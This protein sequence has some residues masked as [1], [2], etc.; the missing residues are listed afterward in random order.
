MTLSSSNCI[1]SGQGGSLNLPVQLVPFFMYQVK[2]DK[3]PCDKRIPTSRLHLSP[4][5]LRRPSR[6]NFFNIALSTT[7]TAQSSTWRE[8][9]KRKKRFLDNLKKVL[10][11]SDVLITI[12]SCSFMRVDRCSVLGHNDISDMKSD[13]VTVTIRCGCQGSAKPHK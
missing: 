5:Y 3:F 10:M 6:T 1:R 8:L 4:A 2:F 12:T 9:R 13:M 7:L 11:L